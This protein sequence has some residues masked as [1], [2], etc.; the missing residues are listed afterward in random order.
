MLRLSDDLAIVQTVD[1]FAPVVDDPYEY[2]AIAAANSMSDVFAMGGTVT[3][4]LNI[5]GFP[6]DLELGILSEILRGGFDKVQ[7][8]GGVIAGGHTI[9]DSEPKYGLAVTGMVHPDRVWAKAGARPGDVLFLTKPLGSGVL[10]TA[11]KQDRIGRDGLEPAIATMLRLN[12]GARDVAIE[13][14]VNAA[15]DITGFG[16]AGHA[17]EIAERSGVAIHIDS[18]G[19]PVLPHVLELLAAGVMAGGLGRNRD[20]FTALAE[21][22]TV[23]SGLPGELVALAFDPQTS[24]GL[25][26]SIPAAAADSFARAFADANEPLWQIGMVTEGSGVHLAGGMVV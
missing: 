16:L 2:G 12:R 14:Q 18:R 17:A 4:A 24:G 7:E 9:T 26:F 20:H 22:V 10:T 6:D 25:L 8:A 5:V 21:G 23:D 3:M 11:A 19:V 13:H 15:T 1:F